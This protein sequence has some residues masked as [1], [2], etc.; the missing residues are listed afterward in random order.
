[1]VNP[2]ATRRRRR[3]A[4]PSRRRRRSRRR[5]RV[6]VNSYRRRY[7]RLRNPSGTWGG[8]FA[9]LGLG[10]LGGLVAGGMDWGADYLPW[11]AW[12][13]ALSLF[14]VG[15]GSSILV[16]KL[17]DIRLGAGLAG[18]T[19]ALVMNRVRQIV[20]LAM[21]KEPAGN[22]NGESA[23]AGAVV[24]S[25]GAGA[26]MRGRGAGAMAPRRNA[27]TVKRGNLLGQSFVQQA[28]ATFAAPGR[29]YGPDSWVYQRG[30][31][32]AV[33]VSKHNL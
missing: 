27:P 28:G 13:Q 16:S 14:G 8:S 29:K 22:G 5:G 6:S 3:R 19:T 23:G 15:A 12:A 26:V 10:G 4:N 21:V 33:Y 25:R 31:A 1:M 7:P 20:A 18:G 11:P 2:T 9:S 17:A 24:R 32:Q 30:G